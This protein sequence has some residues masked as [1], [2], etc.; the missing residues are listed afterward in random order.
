[1]AGVGVSVCCAPEQKSMLL[2]QLVK[3]N[4]GVEYLLHGDER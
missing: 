1:M 3:T 4:I 2:H